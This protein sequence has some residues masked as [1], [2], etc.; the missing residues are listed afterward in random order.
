MAAQPGET[1]S[2]GKGRNGLFT[3]SI[4][5]VIQTQG[6]SL[7]DMFLQVSARVDSISNNSQVPYRGCSMTY[8]YY[9][10]QASAPSAVLGQ[11]SSELK[12]VG[13]S[14]FLKPDS[15]SKDVWNNSGKMLSKGYLELEAKN[16]DLSMLF[17]QRS[18]ELG[19]V[20]G[21]KGI[22]E[23]QYQIGRYEDAMAFFY[24][25]AELGNS[26]AMSR[27][28]YMFELGKGTLEDYPKAIFWYRK[29][30]ALGNI[31]SMIQIGMIYGFGGDGVRKDQDTAIHWLEMAAELGDANTMNT[32]GVIYASGK[33]FGIVP[34]KDYLKA[35]YW[36]NKAIELGNPTSMNQLGYMFQL[37]KG[38]KQDYIKAIMWYKKAYA[39]YDYSAAKNIGY[40][41]QHGL[42]VSKDFLLAKDWYEIAASNGV[43]RA[44]K[45]LA[46][47]Y[48]EGGYGIVKDEEKASQ[49]RNQ[50]FGIPRWRKQP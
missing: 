46:E 11:I 16:T 50:A 29:A 7:D 30:A 15:I 42:G 5:N 26:N 44:M 8:K 23:V 22:G 33:E 3:E 21:I 38:V 45:Y 40:M 19:C 47:I 10:A 37:G 34:K 49:W 4:L 24:R 48:T 12:G 14:I 36:Y 28:G 43:T 9:F 20:E 17:F 31:Y 41:Y 6:L 13:A 27:L 39:L 1:A 32:L 18:T 25:A 35:I 2:D